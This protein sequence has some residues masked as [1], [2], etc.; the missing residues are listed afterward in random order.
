[1]NF[2]FSP[3]SFYNL[4][5]EHIIIYLTVHNNI[6]LYKLGKVLN[7]KKIKN[8]YFV[9][10]D[11]SLKPCHT[12]REGAQSICEQC[13]FTRDT[14][15]DNFNSKKLKKIQL[16]KNKEIGLSNYTY[17]NIQ[18]IK[19]IE[20]RGVKIGYGALSSY[21]TYTRNLEPKVDEKFK[22]YFDTILSNQ[23]MVTDFL[24][25]IFKKYKIEKSY[26]FN[27]SH[28]LYKTSLQSMY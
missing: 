28:I 4:T 23:I 24:L 11:G 16:P 12:N 21:I 10:C 25:N 18:D 9:S 3:K 27:V 14:G 22:T 13:K 19:Q 26:F 15:L 17:R 7:N 20:Y 6:V 5:N 2:G 8:V 1:M